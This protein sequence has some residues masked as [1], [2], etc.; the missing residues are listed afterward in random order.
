[1]EVGALVVRAGQARPLALVRDEAVAG[2]G[3]RRF[4][5]N[6]TDHHVVQRW[7]VGGEVGQIDTLAAFEKRPCRA[8]PVQEGPARRDGHDSPI[9]QE[10]LVVA[11]RFGLAVGPELRVDGIAAGAA[12]GV[13][14]N[15]LD[16]QL[17]VGLPAGQADGEFV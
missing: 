15:A 11:G 10:Q 14:P 12:I 16:Q 1:M 5:V 3:D 4:Q 13:D 7:K 17:A 2:H 8:P 9:D 6:L